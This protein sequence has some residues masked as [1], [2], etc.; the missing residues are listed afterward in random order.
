MKWLLNLLESGHLGEKRP[1]LRRIGESPLLSLFFANFL[2]LLHYSFQLFPRSFFQRID[3][4][5]EQQRVLARETLL[6]IANISR[7]SWCRTG[8]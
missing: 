5:F 4:L 1:L 6:A 7:R 3:F 2:L 8:T